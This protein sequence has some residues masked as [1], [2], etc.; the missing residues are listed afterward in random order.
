MYPKY[1]NLLLVAFA[2]VVF[3]FVV[4]KMCIATTFLL[5]LVTEVSVAFFK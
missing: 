4:D 3:V 1:K 2:T 5:H